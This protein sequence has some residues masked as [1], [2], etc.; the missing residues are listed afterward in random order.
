MKSDLEWLKIRLASITEAAVK[1]RLGVWFDESAWIRAI[2]ADALRH[3]AEVCES[4]IYPADVLR[5]EA[6]R[7]KKP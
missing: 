7:L 6:D 5:E 3:A 1:E 4:T 2:Q